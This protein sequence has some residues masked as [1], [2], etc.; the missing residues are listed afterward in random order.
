MNRPTKVRQHPTAF[1]AC[2]GGVGGI[3]P[4]KAKKKRAMGL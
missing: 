2:F 3:L 4:G 1:G